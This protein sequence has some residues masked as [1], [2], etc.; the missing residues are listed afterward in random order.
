MQMVTLKY[1]LGSK[2]SKNVARNI[3][4]TGVSGTAAMSAMSTALMGS[5]LPI[6]EKESAFFQSLITTN[7]TNKQNP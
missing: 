7:L 2:F 6:A 3:A 5:T 1:Q 4:F